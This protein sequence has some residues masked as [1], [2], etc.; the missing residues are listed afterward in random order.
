MK[1]GL[2]ITSIFILLAGA[3]KYAGV[4]YS[5]AQLFGVPIIIWI[6]VKILPKPFSITPNA[7]V[8]VFLFAFMGVG[9][10][11][12]IELLKIGG[13]SVARFQDDPIENQS[14]IFRAQ[15]S[16]IF[17]RLSLESE[18]VRYPTKIKGKKAARNLMK[19]EKRAGVVWGSTDMLAVTFRAPNNATLL[20]IVGPNVTKF[21]LQELPEL[22]LARAVSDI[23]IAWGPGI[24]AD[25]F[26]AYLF[27][28]FE[29][30]SLQK[31]E[32]L[33]GQASSI[34]GPWKW[35]DHRAYPYWLQGTQH[36]IDAIDG[37]FEPAELD[38]AD[39]LLRKAASFLVV[40]DSNPELLSAIYNNH[41]IV[42]YLKSELQDRPRL[43]EKYRSEF[44]RAAERRVRNKDSQ[45]SQ[46]IK[47]AA[48]SNY[49]LFPEQPSV[50]SKKGKPHGNKRKY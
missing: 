20:D 22:Y 48:T 26:I 4:D 10:S 8:L 16:S 14:R 29:S 18:V 9:I 31:R 46:N 13:V 2:I 15:L 43:K 33:I 45:L 6:F 23:K 50:Y 34:E 28:A 30:N 32:S 21:G 11:Y 40:S 7:G 3:F 44:K 24:P 49:N 37:E 36:I 27:S 38:C 19:K 12:N 5:Y 42:V 17:D 1:S 39:T 41:A 47:L 25:V 35:M